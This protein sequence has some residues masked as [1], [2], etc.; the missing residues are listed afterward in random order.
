MYLRTMHSIVPPVDHPNIMFCNTAGAFTSVSPPCV[1]KGRRLQ[2]MPVGAR[3]IVAATYA[4]LQRLVNLGDI[5]HLGAA[6]AYDILV[7]RRAVSIRSAIFSTSGAMH[8]WATEFVLY[9][10][11]LDDADGAEHV[12]RITDGGTMEPS[13]MN[14][15]QVCDRRAQRFCERPHDCSVFDCIGKDVFG[16][17]A[18]NLVTR[19]LCVCTFLENMHTY[20]AKPCGQEGK[21]S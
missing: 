6:T 8:M 3:R 19:S 17:A 2:G 7:D 9:V 16:R 1:Y 13:F 5:K 21:D 4:D 12:R 10:L 18:R 20:C 11:K 14:T 15:Q